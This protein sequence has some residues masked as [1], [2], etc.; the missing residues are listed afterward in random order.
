MIKTM[1]SK[2]RKPCGLD[3]SKQKGGFI[4]SVCYS[5]KNG[6]QEFCLFLYLEFTRKKIPGTKDCFTL[7]EKAEIGV[8]LTY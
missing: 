1:I 6:F 7:G 4:L 5:T 3:W 2:E 8:F